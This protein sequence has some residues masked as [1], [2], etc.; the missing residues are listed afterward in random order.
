MSEEQIT[1]NNGSYSAD[2]IPG[3]SPKTANR[4][5]NKTCQKL[6][7]RPKLK[8]RCVTAEQVGNRTE[9]VI[10]E[11]AAAVFPTV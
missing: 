9:K 4:I 1:P 11:L 5:D 6:M 2:S 3:Y 7:F 10:K 8:N